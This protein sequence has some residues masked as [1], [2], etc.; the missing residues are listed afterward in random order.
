[1]WSKQY[2][3]CGGTAIPP[4]G[5]SHHFGS[6]HGTRALTVKPKGYAILTE[7]MLTGPEHDGILEL[8]LADRTRISRLYNLFFG[9]R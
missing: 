7:N 4:R 8:L 9:R 1:M 3:V 6:T 5:I 2:D